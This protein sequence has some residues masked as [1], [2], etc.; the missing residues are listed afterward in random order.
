METPVDKRGRQS[1][2]GPSNGLGTNG[3]AIPVGSQCFWGAQEW[4][5]LRPYLKLRKELITVYLENALL[6]SAYLF[7]HIS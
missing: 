6:L 3:I 4:S 7:S 5:A 2:R 1:P